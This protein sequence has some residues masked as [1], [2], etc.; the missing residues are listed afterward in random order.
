MVQSNRIK[1]FVTELRGG[2]LKITNQDPKSQVSA[3]NLDFL[4]SFK[5]RNSKVGFATAQ[6]QELEMFGQAEMS[7]TNK[8]IL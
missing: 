7:T 3:K 8:N 6:L 4:V 1:D 2:P 5:L